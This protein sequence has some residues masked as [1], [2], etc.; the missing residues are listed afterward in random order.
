MQT[1]ATPARRLIGRRVGA[2]IIIQIRPESAGR[3]TDRRP[4]APRAIRASSHSKVQ[5]AILRRM[6]R[7]TAPAPQPITRG[8][9]VIPGRSRSNQRW[10]RRM[11]P[12][13]RAGRIHQVVRTRPYSPAAI[14][15]IASSRV[16]PFRNSLASK[17][18]NLRRT[19]ASAI[20][21]TTPRPARRRCRLRDYRTSYQIKRRPV[22]IST[23]E[24]PQRTRQCGCR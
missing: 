13:R 11:A 9:G 7:D 1:R 16:S 12:F 14:P 8:P 24:R 20:L 10:A 15:K 23:D 3:A 17:P 2:V 19:P 4:A 5:A 21:A 22:R 18:R 6:I